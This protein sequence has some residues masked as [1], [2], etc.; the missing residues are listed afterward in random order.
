MLHQPY[1]QL[2]V[3]HCLHIYGNLSLPAAIREAKSSSGVDVTC[4]G[5]Q[6]SKYSKPNLKA[7]DNVLALI[8]AC[9]C[10]QIKTP[11]LHAT[12]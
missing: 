1:G 7:H 9:S 3:N 12:S 10:K 8:T 5:G 11:F 6:T 2:N 4:A